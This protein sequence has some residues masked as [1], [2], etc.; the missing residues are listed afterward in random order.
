MA[1][2]ADVVVSTVRDITERQEHTALWNCER[3]LTL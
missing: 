3:P 1:D 2:G